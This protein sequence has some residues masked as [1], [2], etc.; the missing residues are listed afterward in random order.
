MKSYPF[1]ENR[2]RILRGKRHIRKEKYGMFF[3]MCK[4]KQTKLDLRVA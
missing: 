4:N 2:W 3:I 1:Q